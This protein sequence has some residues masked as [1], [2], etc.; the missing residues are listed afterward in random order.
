MP[1][2]A[3]P[4]RRAAR[5]RASAQVAVQ[6]LPPERRIAAETNAWQDSDFGLCMMLAPALR[7]RNDA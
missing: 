2:K 1:R 4:N 7:R 5:R 3:D 6:A